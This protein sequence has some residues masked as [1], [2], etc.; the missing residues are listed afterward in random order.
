MVDEA[1]ITGGDS[2]AHSAGRLNF[3]RGALTGVSGQVLQLLGSMVSLSIIA[4]NVSAGTMGGYQT[5]L[6]VWGFIAIAA[7][8]QLTTQVARSHSP[9]EAAGLLPWGPLAGVGSLA[10]AATCAAFL[11]HG[12]EVRIALL[13]LL[14]AIFAQPMVEGLTGLMVGLGMPLGLF[15][16]QLLRT[17]VR[18]VSVILLAVSGMH[19]NGAALAA[20]DDVV[21]VSAILGVAAMLGPGRFRRLIAKRSRIPARVVLVS[22]AS[23]AVASMGWQVIQRTDLLAVSYF[24]SGDDAGRYAVTLKL[25][26]VGGTLFAALMTFSLPMLSQAARAGEPARAYADASVLGCLLGWPALVL[27]AGFGP[28]WIDVLFGNAYQVPEAVVVILCTAFLIHVGMGPS[29]LMLAAIRSNRAILIIGLAV[30][31]LAIALNLALVPKFGLVGGATATAIAM[32]TLNVSSLAALQSVVGASVVSRRVVVWQVGYLVGL[33]AAVFA[34]RYSVGQSIAGLAAAIGLV[35]VVLAVSLRTG[36]V[37]ELFGSLR[38]TQR[39]PK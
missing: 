2:P 22:A 11:S 31:L 35:M 19:L 23:L 38:G 29:G 24:L 28:T 4:R 37:R 10:L 5:A 21:A 1:P 6:A 8:L 32:A 15:A 14:P 36:S 26:E 33:G 25:V 9:E 18:V 16:Q 13:A 12:S 3:L 34:A 27:F 20:V 17:V 7:G 30:A 39:L